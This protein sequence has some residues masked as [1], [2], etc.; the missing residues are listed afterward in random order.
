VKSISLLHPFTPQAAGVV[1][2]S[3]AGYHSQPHLK[4]LQLLAEQ[5]GHSCR[6]EYFTPRCFH[7][8]FKTQKV[9]YT[10]Y[11]VDFTW[12]GNH[13]KW[14]KQKSSSCLR[15]YK[16]QTPDV[17]IINMSGHSS[18]FSHQLAKTILK[19]KKQYIA[20]L[21]GQHY[22]DTPANREYYKNA[23]HILVHTQLQKR[24]MERLELFKGLDIRVFPLGVDC[25]VFSPKKT[26][27]SSP[28]LLYVGRIVEL[29][30]IHLAIEAI[31][32]LKN[33]GFPKAHLNIIGPIFSEAYFREL[34]NLVKDG[35]LEPNVSFLGH[36]PHSE[37]P[38]YFQE[39]DLF[40]LPSDKETFGMVMIEAMACGTP[41]AGID[42][43]GGPA[44]VIVQ[45]KNGL[46]S[47]PENYCKTVLD[48]FLNPE[49][50]KNIESNARKK[51][52]DEYSIQATF[53]VLRESVQS[54]LKV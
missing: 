13:K 36:K 39:A 38:T 6:M 23:N 35:N 8:G 53:K 41:V 15:A 26:K 14:K 11:P 5:T 31:R 40:T 25:E 32:L 44:D 28:Q 20:M 4:A 33:N 3:V 51:V 10:F 17:T 24:E 30:R 29:K 47:T 54:A 37:L 52:L 50:A 49:Q 45:L 1:E 42:C 43:P 7:Y 27:N 19:N 16:A 9:D 46:L 21:G 2:K 12:N 34:K 48:Y 18:P 22:T